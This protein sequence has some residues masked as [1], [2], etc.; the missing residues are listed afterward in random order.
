MLT[1]RALLAARIREARHLDLPSFTTG[2]G[3][4][5]SITVVAEALATETTPSPPRSPLGDSTPRAGDGT[6][7]LP[8]QERI[9]LLGGSNP[10]TGRPEHGL[11]VYRLYPDEEAT[12]IRVP[13]QLV[14]TP[15][16][17]IGSLH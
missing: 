8:G 4:D 9:Y 2:A 14:G 17:W 13:P 12:P 10:D 6:R 7:A 5:A 11:V 3:D 15:H 16:F 1:D